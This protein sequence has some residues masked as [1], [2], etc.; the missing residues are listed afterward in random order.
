MTKNNNI[1]IFFIIKSQATVQFMHNYGV[2]K[3]NTEIK[4]NLLKI[5]LKHSHITTVGIGIGFSHF[6]IFKTWEIFT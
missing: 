5:T 4:V 3:K 2:E 6:L 1:V